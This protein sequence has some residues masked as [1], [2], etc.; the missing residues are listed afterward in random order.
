V[1]SYDL[2]IVGGGIGGSALASVMA[3]AGRSVLLLE[4]TTVYPDRV[5]GEW[6]APWGVVEVRRVGLYDLLV[7][8]GGHVLARHVSY[9]ESRSPE[10]SETRTL[11][12]SMFVEGVTGPLTIGHP[13]HCQTLFDEAK[14]SGATALRGVN[15]TSIA[16]GAPSSVTYEHEGKRHTATA[17]LIVGADGRVSAAREAAGIKLHQDKPH[18][19]FAGLLVEGATGW[20]DDLQ[21]IGTE[22][23]FGFLAFPQG[24]GRVRV[25][26][27]YALDQRSRFA[28]AEGPKKFLEAFRMRSSP[29]N[30]HLAD[31]EPASPLFS[32]FNHDSWTDEPFAPGI[33]LIGDA[34]GWNDPISGLGLSITYRDVR[35]VSEI[36]KATSD[37]SRPDFS[38]YAEE[39]GERMRRLRFAAGLQAALDMEFGEA[40]KARRQSFHERSAADP[41]LGMHAFAI[42]AGPEKLPPDFFTEAH[43]ARVLGLGSE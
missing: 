24:K 11:P 32:Y 34:A 33:V 3:K 10:E 16:P 22:N 1:S 26:G 37:W 20:P 12:L 19:W 18:H 41:T 36:L 40:A 6:I 43:R 42:M 21:A 4:Q 7:S 15:V 23:D 29:L 31:A 39:R 17:P 38:S 14:R 35:I 13:H 5:R 25:Y 8:A 9:D 27:G 2:I 30:A 28:G